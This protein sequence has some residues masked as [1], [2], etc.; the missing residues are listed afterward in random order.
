MER[1]NTAPAFKGEQKWT[2]RGGLKPRAVMI[3][4]VVVTDACVITPGAQ[5]KVVVQRV[6]QK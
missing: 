4:G 5:I 6:F 2:I 3:G 1:K